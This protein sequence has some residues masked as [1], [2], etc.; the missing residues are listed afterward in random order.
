MVK[1]SGACG[2][3]SDSTYSHCASQCVFTLGA[4]NVYAAACHG[5]FGGLMGVAFCVVVVVVLCKMR[6][7]AICEAAGVCNCATVVVL[8]ALAKLLSTMSTLW[9]MARTRFNCACARARSCSFKSFIAIVAV[10]PSC[11]SIVTLFS[12]TV[13]NQPSRSSL[14]RSSRHT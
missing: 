6:V 7:V 9:F 8:N 4:N 12:R 11:K 13:S 3:P 1:S 14:L 10:P 5:S 2:S